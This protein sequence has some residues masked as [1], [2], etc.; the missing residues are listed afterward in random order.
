MKTLILLVT[1]LW[2]IPAPAITPVN[3]SL[4]GGVAIK[5][6]DPVAYFTDGHPVKG[7]R[8]FTFTWND[9][10]WQFA[11][12]A[13]RDLFARDPAAYAPQYGGYCAWA[14]SQGYTAGIDPASWKIVADKLYLNYDPD[15]Q[16][17]WAQDIPGFIAKAEKNW[18]VLLKK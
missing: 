9:A 4:I 8:E 17:R 2:A 18:P 10:T 11:S 15:V 12:A 5:G 3:R 14:V 16:A 1:L 6:Y 7:S 13:H